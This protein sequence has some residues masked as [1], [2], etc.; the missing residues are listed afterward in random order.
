[1]IK[2]FVEILSLSPPFEIKFRIPSMPS[3]RYHAAYFK[4]LRNI[5][6]FTKTDNTI[7][8]ILLDIDECDVDADPCPLDEYCSNT[9]GSFTC[10]Y[11]DDFSG[12]NFCES[13]VFL[14]CTSI[15]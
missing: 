6:C 7:I 12:D 1:M 8:R 3:S 9:V 2:L 10:Y 13:K 4:V 14:F 11:T 5:Y 15:S